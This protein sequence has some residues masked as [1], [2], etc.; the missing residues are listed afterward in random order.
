MNRQ[1]YS[2]FSRIEV[3]LVGCE[4]EDAAAALAGGLESGAGP[5]AAVG[6]DN[7]GQG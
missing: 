2:V 7:Q 1:P 3:D 5:V 4:A 6:D